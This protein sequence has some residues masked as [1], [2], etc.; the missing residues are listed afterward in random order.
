[1]KAAPLPQNE[2]ERL[3]E[4][5]SYDVLDTEA[6]QLFDDLTALASQICETP[7]ALI[8]LIDPN[9]QWFKSRVDRKSVV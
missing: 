3:A 4:L 9:R 7:I 6:E 5:L 8:S 2:D 1:M